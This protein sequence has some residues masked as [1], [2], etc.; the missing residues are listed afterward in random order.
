MRCLVMAAVAICF[1]LIGYSQYEYLL[2]KTYAQRLDSF[3]KIF[4]RLIPDKDSTRVFGEFEK[5]KNFAEKNNEKELS[6]EMDLQR[7]YYNSRYSTDRVKV[8][9]DLQKMITE[10]NEQKV[11]NVEARATYVLARYYWEEVGNYELSFEQ[12]LYL[13]ELLRHIPAREFPDKLIYLF[14]LGESYFFFGEY[15]QAIPWFKEA[16]RIEPIEYNQ[17]YQN[18]SRN[19]LG[20]CYQKMNMLDSSDYYFNQILHAGAGKNFEAWEGIAKGNLGY[21]LYLRK[22]YEQAIPFLQSDIATA[23]KLEDWSLASGSLMPLAN[24]YFTRRQYDQAV[25]AA[26]KAQNYIRQTGDYKRLA[27][28][29]PLMARISALDR[30]P[31]AVAAYIDSALIVR[32][33][34]SRKFNT[35]KLLKAAQKME[36]EKHRNAL[37]DTENQKKINKLERNTF[38][39]ILLLL[40]VVGWVVYANQRR[41]YIQKQIQSDDRL[42]KTEHELQKARVELGDFARRITEKNAMLEAMERELGASDNTDALNQLRRI[43]ILTEEE[44]DHFRELFSKVYGDYLE[45]LKVKIPELTPA[46]VRY[47]TL[48][49]LRF[50]NKEMAATLGVT[51]QSMRVTWHRI[52]KKL[53]LPDEGTVEELVDSI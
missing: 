51:P 7:A 6:L 24:I 15:A 19:T 20:L 26:L 2:H 16:L 5:I 11:V 4:G 36:L 53:N 34:L 42:R 8:I 52:R 12:Y 31:D 17:T 25:E 47:M 14:R 30:K 9:A 43:T 29:Y 48:A 46:E 33:S 28:L 32:D 49:K 45:R 37:K 18:S 1:P 35:I 38:L 3:T 22:Q 44:W 23:E 10:A 27:E 13:S 41:R 21:N 50:T 40:A 39:A